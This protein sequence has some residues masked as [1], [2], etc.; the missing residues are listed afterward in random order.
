MQ[1]KN[2]KQAKL[3][4][5][6]GALPNKT[7]LTSLPY[8]RFSKNTIE[9]SKLIKHEAKKTSSPLGIYL[10]ISCKHGVKSL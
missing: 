9:N 4:L 5:A 6:K 7:N 2:Q 8:R 3:L 1:V 10:F